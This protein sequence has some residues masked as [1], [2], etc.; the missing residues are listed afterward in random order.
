MCYGAAAL[1]RPLSKQR[2]SHWLCI[3]RAYPTEGRSL[4]LGITGHSSRGDAA[5]AC[6]LRGV[7]VDVIC[8]AALRSTPAPFISLRYVLGLS[9]AQSVLRAEAEGPVGGLLSFFPSRTAFF[10]GHMYGVMIT[11]CRVQFQSM[12][13]GLLTSL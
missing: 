6:R 1:G 8:A 10:V 3:E 13:F 12:T 5:S 9:L 11:V 2:L 4:P 7:E